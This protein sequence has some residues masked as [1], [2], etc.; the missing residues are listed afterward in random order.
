MTQD[1]TSADSKLVDTHEQTEKGAGFHSCK[2]PS[3]QGKDYTNQAAE[4]NKIYS[5]TV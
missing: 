1:A 2:L 3:S 4:N 5:L